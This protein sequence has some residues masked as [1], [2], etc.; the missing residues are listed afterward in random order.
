[1]LPE[2]QGKGYGKLVLIEL[3][4]CAIAN[5]MNAISLNVNRSQ[6]S[7][8]ILSNYNCERKT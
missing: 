8:T 3:I 6:Y 1:M 5:K 4:V 2:T 7:F